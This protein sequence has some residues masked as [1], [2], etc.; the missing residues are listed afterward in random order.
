MKNDTL[1]KSI[2]FMCFQTRYL[3]ITTNILISFT[4]QTLHVLILKSD[5]VKKKKSVLALLS[6]PVI[7]NL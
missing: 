2:G 5:F 7:S 3:L 1:N 4:A 6:E